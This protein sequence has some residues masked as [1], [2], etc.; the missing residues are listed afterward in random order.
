MRIKIS[1]SERKFSIWLPTCL[2]VNSLGAAICTKVINNST[3][4]N[5]LS[6]DDG[7]KVSYFAVRRLFKTIRKCRHILHGQPLVSVNSVDGD[8]VEIW[9]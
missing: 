8:V 4:T 1:T 9:I 6:I 7:F 3:G 5:E 2:F